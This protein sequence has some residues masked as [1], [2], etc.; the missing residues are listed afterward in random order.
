MIFEI[1]K[2]AL[3]SLRANKLRTF[4]SMLGIIIGVGAVIAI[5]SIG[6][7]A[8]N[9]ITAQ[10]SD[11]GSNV[12]TIFPGT[13]KGWG[14]RVSKSSADVFTMELADYIEEVSPSVK[15]VVPISQ[16]SGLLIKGNFN[17]QTTIIGTNAD[18]QVLNNYNLAM[19]QFINQGD[20]DTSRNIIVL[21]SGLA[22]ELFG[23]NNPL[24]E[25]MKL[26]YQGRDYLFTV[27]GVMEEK[28]KGLAGDLN[29][30]AYIPI[31]TFMKKLSN[32]PYQ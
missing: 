17:I 30:Q 10:I 24:G 26:S 29:G 32:S 9:Q 6:S 5:V 13:S 11:L 12:I 19:G 16:G 2:L 22:E 28:G 3:N 14:G 18:Y 20:L 1:I 25:K 7:G 21:G 4:L 23:S 8:T 31:T 27:I 15:R